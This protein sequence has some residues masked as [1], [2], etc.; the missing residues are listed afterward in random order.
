MR[1]K[2]YRAASVADAMA[3][4]RRELGPDALILS[5]RRVG[6]GVELTAAL[7]GDE[8]APLIPARLAEPPPPPR[9]S[10]LLDAAYHAVPHHLA[11]RLAGPDLAGSLRAAWHFGPLPLQYSPGPSAPLMLIGMPGAGKTLTTARLATRL[12][13]AGTQPLVITADGRR[14]GGAEELAAYT[15]LLGLTLLAASTPATLRRA[16]TQAPPG[17]PILIDTAGTNPFDAAETDALAS[18]VQDSGAT[19][20]LV[21]AAGAHPEEAAEQ[22]HAFASLGVSHLL[23]TRL[24]IARRLG[25]VLAAAAAPGLTLTEAGIGTGATDGLVRLT[26]EF[27]AAR[28]LATPPRLHAGAPDSPG[29]D[30]QA[31]STQASDTQELD[32]Q[33]LDRRALHTLPSEAPSHTMRTPVFPRA[34]ARAAESWDMHYG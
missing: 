9:K 6:E 30:T 14:A 33:A 29:L 25:C 8:A 10:V 18:L 27:L 7:D 21:M 20:I 26:P 15:R 23:P 16:L 24:D 13:L 3:Q 2:I 17:A 11:S 19:P 22:A 5:T 32:T 1:L 28:L 31:L 4:L 34:R 12:V